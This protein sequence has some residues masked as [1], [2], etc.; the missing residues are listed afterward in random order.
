MTPTSPKRARIAPKNPRPPRPASLA[1]P[2]APV[3]PEPSFEALGLFSDDLQVQSGL[4]NARTMRRKSEKAERRAVILAR[5]SGM[6]WDIIGRH[7]EMNGE[8]L[9]RRYA[10]ELS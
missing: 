1:R 10:Q 2:P 7:L 6:S 8:T 9:R 5:E 3:A 4:E